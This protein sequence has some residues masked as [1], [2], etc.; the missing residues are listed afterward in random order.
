MMLYDLS[1]FLQVW[2][3]PPGLIIAMFVVGQGVKWRHRRLGRAIQYTAFLLLWLFS[4]PIITQLMINPL[5]QQ[6][7]HLKYEKLA[8]LPHSAIVTLGAG[9]DNAQEYPTRLVL[10]EMSFK[11][12]NYAAHLHRQTSLPIIVSGGNRGRYAETEAHLMQ[13]TLADSYAIR[14]LAIEDKSKNT[15]EESKLIVPLLKEHH[16][17]QIY[18]VTHAWHMPR[19]MAMFTAALKPYDI[20]VIAAPTGYL[21]LLSNERWAN[22]L[23][24]MRA[25]IA[26]GYV[27]HEYLG[28]AWY[29]LSYKD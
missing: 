20:T 7:P 6:Y 27:L 24:S 13:Q 4:T 5:Q 9:V 14:T 16:L 18:L 11:R 29:R 3:L 22:Y 23:P 15:W 17:K 10:S 25:L 26:S 8:V 28:L 21:N 2:L 12:L 1:H 19:S